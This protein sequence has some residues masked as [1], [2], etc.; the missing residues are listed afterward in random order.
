MKLFCYGTIT[1][2]VAATLS[3]CYVVQGIPDRIVGGIRAATSEFPFYATPRGD[4]LC[5]ATL[6]HKDILISAAHCGAKTWAAGVALGCAA[7]GGKGCR[8]YATV[9]SYIHPGYNA[10]TKLHDVM[11]IKI[12]GT[13]PEPYVKLNFNSSLP[14]LNQSLTAIG[15]GTT[16]EGGSISRSLLRVN[17][18][19]AASKDC[20]K[21]YGNLIVDSLM[22]CNAFPGGGKDTCQGDSGGPLFLNGTTTQIG[23]VSF[24]YGCA[25]SGVPAVNTRISGYEKW[26]QESICKLSSH[27]PVSCLLGLTGGSGVAP[28]HP[29]TGARQVPPHNNIIRTAAKTVCTP[30]GRPCLLPSQCCDSGATCHGRL[31]G[32]VCG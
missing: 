8:N 15:Y 26:I 7:L 27:P 6:I 19:T 3:S 22:V 4:Y 28:S 16:S 11:L 30:K 29:A 32:K 14:A 23:V 13:A 1:A 12:N 5:G 9:H 10:S 31:N 21:I 20:K 18:F 17:V 2:I 24:G 25:R